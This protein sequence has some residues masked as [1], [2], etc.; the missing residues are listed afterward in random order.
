MA[1]KVAMVGFAGRVPAI[2]AA[3]Y[4]VVEMSTVGDLT[5]IDRAEGEVVV[6]LVENTDAG[7]ALL[8]EGGS[9]PVI[10]GAKD[11]IAVFKAWSADAAA[12]V[13][14]QRIGSGED[15][16]GA[17]TDDEVVEWIKKIFESLASPTPESA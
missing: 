12:C 9:D 13:I 1:Q 17:S 4:E 15:A 8:A 16:N 5:S 11:N 2:K 7:C 3:G 6:V 14:E 10:V